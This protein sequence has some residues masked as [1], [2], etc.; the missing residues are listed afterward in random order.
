MDLCLHH[1]AWGYY[2]QGPGRLG[3]SGDFVTASDVGSAFGEAVA[4]QLVELDLRLDHPDPFDLVEVG[5][6]RGLLARDLLDALAERAPDLRRRVRCVLVDTSPGMRQAASAIVPEARVVPPRESPV[7]ATG[8]VL[9]VELLDALP[10]HR[11]RRRAGVLREVGVGLDAEGGLVEVDLAPDPRVLAL[12]ARYGAAAEEGDEAEVCPALEEEVLS[13]GRGLARGF[14]LVVDYGY[15]A[16]TLYGPHHGAGT[17][18]AYHRHRVHEEVLARAGRQ[19]LTAHVN[20]SHLKDAAAACGFRWLGRTSQDRFLI[21]NG[22][23]E[24]FTEVDPEAWAKPAQ[25]ERRRAALQLLHPDG[26]GRRFQVV[27]LSKG[28]VGEAPLLG[29]ADPFARPATTP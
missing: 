6:G 2:A 16:R 10:V 14:V 11:L 3:P 23:L 1:P 13:L 7:D 20:F 28:E 5:C 27:V 24:R 12:A 21:S 8:C 15:D 25:V 9:A 17:L 22:I 4:H 19:D 18:L 26:M 29:L